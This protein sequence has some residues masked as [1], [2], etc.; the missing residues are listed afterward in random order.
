MID[1]EHEVIKMSNPIINSDPTIAIILPVSGGD[2]LEHLKLAVESILNQTF[3]IFK[4]YIC[5][6]GQIEV[7]VDN[8]LQN[9]ISKSDARVIIF[10]N[11]SNIGLPGTLNRALKKIQA[12]FY[13]RMDADDIAHPERI[14]K[15]LNAFRNDSSLQMLGTDCIEIDTD[16]NELFHKKMPVGEKKIR[17]MIFL[18]SPFIHPSVAF[19]SDFFDIVGYYNKSFKQ[20][21][22]IE[23]WARAIVAGIKMN[24]LNEPLL[25]YRVKDDIWRKRSSFVQIK[26]ET[27]VNLYLLQNLRVYSKIPHMLMKTCL[28][29]VLMVLP[30]SFSR[31][32]YKRLR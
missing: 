17:D 5:I 12:E 32:A 1:V 28:R 20:G 15:S 14:E 25:Y 13:F 4:L 31:M 11:E 19:R 26:N 16:G 21:Q 23:L 27:H 3:N 6:D 7:A 22:D 30:N 29:F 10:K 24:N 8:Y 9:D 2:N 18:R